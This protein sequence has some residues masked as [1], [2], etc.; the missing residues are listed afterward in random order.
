ME[1]WKVVLVD[2]HPILI[3]GVRNMLDGDQYVVVGEAYDGIQALNVLASS[4]ADILITDIQ[5]PESDGLKLIREVRALHP[6]VRIVVLSMHDERSIVM[7]AIRLGV[8]AYLLKNINRQKLLRALSSVRADV[9]YISEEI[10]HLLVEDLH[11]RVRERL[12][13]D[14]ELEILR[15]IARE[16]SNKQIADT[17]F[18]SERTVESHRKNIF[19]KT[20]TRSVVGLIKYAIKNGLI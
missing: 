5:M 4:Q 1:R 3:D 15:L 14:R 2:D 18:I 16:F 20:N 7:D 12:L 9:F 11:A 6:E 17:L 10:S 13:S 19:R 8:K